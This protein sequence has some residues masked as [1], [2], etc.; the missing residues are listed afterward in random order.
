MTK[1]PL[2]NAYWIWLLLSVVS[3]AAGMWLI[4]K[5]ERRLDNWTT[6][7]IILSVLGSLN[8]MT[9]LLSGQTTWFM[10]LFF[11]LC[12]L[13]LSKSKDSMLGLSFAL[14]TIKPQYS[15]LFFAGLIGAKRWKALFVFMS[16]TAVMLVIAAVVLGWQNV[17]FYPQ[18][19]TQKSSGDEFW[20]PQ[21]QCNWRAIFCYFMPYE[22]AYK[23]G[24]AFVFLAMPFVGKL[25]TT[26]KDD[27]DRRR[28]IFALTMLLALMFGPHVNPYDCVLVGV[29]AVLTLPTVSLIEVW[30]IESGP[31]KAWCLLML[32]YPAAGWIIG[33]HNYVFIPLNLALIVCGFLYLKTLNQ[34]AS[35]SGIS[36]ALPK[37]A[38]ES[39]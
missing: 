32:A 39:S 6:G 38:P 17:V 7:V 27:G 20:Y 11:C 1:L 24:F 16:V 36:P 35:E 30:K 33:S 22:L 12:Y 31:L 28:W 21:K 37:H 18:V 9:V 10:F 19:L 13:F 8:S 3:G 15:F 29:A 23:L 5:K 26:I 25:W 4:L 14:A 34:S 2:I